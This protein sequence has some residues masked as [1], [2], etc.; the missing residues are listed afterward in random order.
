MLDA[1]FDPQNKRFTMQFEG[2]QAG[3]GRSEFI[4]PKEFLASPFVVSL[5]GKEVQ[6]DDDNS[7][8][9]V[10]ENQTHAT[11]EV[12]H[13]H[14]LQEITIQGTTAV[15]ELPF[16]AVIVAAGLAASLAYRRLHR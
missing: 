6:Q 2:A 16:P 10:S 14:G 4:I 9:K 12:E 13:E 8:V 15:P 11:I 7:N 5:D 3:A 1:S